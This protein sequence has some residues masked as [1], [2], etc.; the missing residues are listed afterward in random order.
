MSATIDQRVVEMRFDNQQFER[1]AHE[2]ISTLA[3]LKE[4]L[5][6]SG[7]SKGLATINSE[8]K[9][10]NL[11][12]MNTAVET[13]HA[14][15]SALEVMGVTALANI[16]NQ[17][18]NAGKRIMSALTIDPVKTG[19]SEYE[20]QINAVQTI[21]A[22]TQHNGTNIDQV[23]NALETL[24]QYADKTIYNFTEMTRNI[25]TFTAAGV[26]L[27]TSVDS[28]QGI[29]N[30]A[31][32]SGSTSQQ[33]STAMYQ[34]SQALAAGKVSLM[35]WNSVVNAGMGG[36][37]FQDA[38][39]RTSELLKTG[40]KGAIE[41]YGS[42]RESLT[43]GEWLTTEVL[44]ETLKQFAGA[45]SEADLIA[46][47]FTK[48]QAKEIAAMAKTAEDAAT[49][50]KTFSQ[51]W[52]VM[53]ESAQSGWSQT[54]KILIGDFEEAKSLLTPLAD[55]ATKVIGKMSDA[56]NILL[57]KAL[58]N[59]FSELADKIGKVTGATEA[60]KNATKDYGEVV[61]RVL[62]GEFGN[63]QS[64]WDKLS[65]A[66][67]DWAKVQNMV[68]EKLG[69]SVRH[70]EQLTEAQKNQNGAQATTIE[71]L[72]QMSDAQLKSLGFTKEEI[73][74]FRD[75]A[76]QSEKTGI[77]INDLI[78]DM[79]QL[80]G[81]T[82]LING[83]KNA[84]SG[85]VGVFKAMGEAWGTFFKGMQPETLY[86]MIAGFHKFSLKLRLTDSETGELNENGKKLMRTF[87]GIFALVD[88]VA[89]IVGGGLRLAFKLVSSI[90]GY[91][92]M[93]LLD[94]TA[95][96]GD[97]LVKFREMTD[98]SKLFD[99]A[100][101]AIAPLI[102]KAAKGVKEFGEAFMKLPLVQEIISK[103]QESIAKLKDMDLREI[104]KNIIDGLKNGLGDGATQVIESIMEL[105][106]SLLT[107]IKEVL[108][109]HSPSTEFF[110]IGTNII[111]GLINGIVEGAAKIFT[112]IKD[113]GSSVIDTAS[114][115]GIV[116][117]IGK[118][119]SGIVTIIKNFAKTIIDTV[120]GI[121]I[122][123]LLAIG[124]VAGMIAVV[125]KMSDVLEMF[126][127]P[128]EGLGDVFEG[129][130]NMFE[131]LAKNFKA[132]AWE[133]RTKGILNLAI[134]IGV[135]ALSVSL[136]ASIKGTDL[137]KAVV[138]VAA[139][140][141]VMYVL[142]LACDKLSKAS[143]VI[144]QNGAG[145]KNLNTGL[146][147]I[148]G[149]LLILAFTVK[150]IGSLDPEQ[151]KQ[152]F[153][154]L[155]G[156]VGA[157]A[158]VFAAYGLLVKGKG[159]KS[160]DKA[161]KMLLK[162]SVS[163]LIMVGVAKLIAGMTWEDMGKAG[164]GILGLVGIIGL[165]MT[166]SMI[167]GKKI[168]KI[169]SM[170]F[171]ISSAMLILVGVAK[172]IN[173]MTWEEM[174]KAGA[175]MLG[176]VGVIAILMSIAMIPGKNV[177]KV[178]S[179]LLGI[180]ASMFILV[181]VAKLINTMEWGEMGKAAVGLAGLAGVVALLVMI[182]KLAGNDAPK[183]AGTLIAMSVAIGI[184][185]G[186]AIVLGTIKTENL[187]K[188][189]VAVG[190]L[191]G[192]MTAMIW[193]TRGANDCKGNLIIMTVAIGMMAVAVAALSMIDGTK[194]AG[195]TIAMSVLM[196]MFALMTK[197]AGSVKGSI[198]TLITMT[199]AVGLLAGVLYL[200][201]QLPIEQTIGSAAALS[202]L[203]LAVSGSLAILSIIGNN[204]K[205][206]LMGV[207]SL[208]LMAVPL[209]AF[210]GV[211]ALMQNVQ[212]AMNNVKAL[213]L[214]AGA[215]TL[216]LIPLTIIGTFI[217]QA[218]LGVVS[219]TLMAVPLL[220]FVGILAL[221][222]GIE[223]AK[224]N[225]DALIT[226][227]GSLTDMLIKVAIVGPLALM[228]VTAMYGLVGLIGVIGIMATAVGALMEKFPGLESFLDK[229]IPILEKLSF[230]IGSF[231]GNVISG[232]AEGLTDGLPGIA[233]NLSA[234]MDKLAPFIA[235][236]KTID[237]SAMTGITSL[238]KMVGLVSGA[239]II[240]AIASW[241]TGGSSMETFGTQINAFGDAIVAFSKKVTEG[242][243][244]ET[245]VMAAAN[246]GKLM[247]EMNATIPGT[248]GIVQWFTGEKNMAAFGTQLSAFGS[249]ICEFSKTVSA[250]GAINETAVTAA[251]NAGK[252]M[253]EM[254]SNLTGTGGVVQWFCGEKNMAT[255]GIQLV[256]FGKAICDFSKTV[257]GEG[258]ITEESIT[259]AANAGKLMTEMQSSI[260]PTGGVVQFFTG[261]QNLETFGTQLVAFGE[262]IT[263]FSD[264]V[265]GNVN[266]E[267]VTAAANAG[268]IM[269]TLQNDLPE[270]NWFDGK[271]SLEDFGKKLV[272]FGESIADY[273]ESVNAIDNE[274]VAASISAAKKLVSLT[275]SL[276][277]L[278]MSG[279]DDFK[280]NEIGD[281][282]NDYSDKVVDLDTSAINSSVKTANKLINFINS[283]ASLNT[284][285]ISTFKSAIS[286]LST[287]SLDSL[288]TTFAN[289][290]SKLSNIGSNIIESIINGMKLK[291][292]SMVFAATSMINEV[293]NNI[294]DKVNTFKTAGTE[295]MTKM[296]SGIDSQ[297]GKVGKAA[298][299]ALSTAVKDIRGYYSKFNSAGSYLVTGFA[300]GI[301]ANT[302]KAT[303]KARAMAEAAEKAA[304][305][306]LGIHS[307]S[308][309][310][311]EIAEYMVQG[312]ELGLEDKAPVVEQLS[313]DL[314]VSCTNS[315]LSAI[316]NGDEAI[317]QEIDS[318][319]ENLLNA[320][321][322]G[323]NAK[324][325]EDMKL[326]EFEQGILDETTSIWKEYTDALSNKNDSIV[327]QIGL[328]SAVEKKDKVDSDT[329]VK[330]LQDQINE[331][332]SF[333]NTIASLNTRIAD[334]NLKNA[335]NEMGIE[336][337]A[338]LQSLNSMTDAELTNYA[339]MY[340]QKYAL[341]RHAAT[342]QLTSLQTETEQKLSNLFGGTPVDLNTFAQTFD[343]TM[344]SIEAYVA[345]TMNPERFREIGANWVAGMGEGMISS[346]AAYDA[347][348]QVTN[349]TVDNIKEISG[350]HS[351]SKLFNQEIGTYWTAGIAEGMKTSQT[352]V[353][354]VGTQIMF[355]L[356][357][358][359]KGYYSNFL[360]AGS[361]LVNGLAN[362][363]RANMASA[364]AAAEEMANAVANAARSALDIHS[365]S[366]VFYK[367]G[368]F[369]G[370][371]FANALYD[372][373]S[374][375][376]K[377]GEEI[378]YSAEGGMSAALGRISDII[379]NG[380]DAQPT[381]RPILDLSNIESGVGAMN[382][383][384]ANTTPVG[385]LANV[386][387][388]SS[389]M[390][391]RNQNG[392][393]DDIVSA[394]NGL[395]KDLGNVGGTTYNIDGITYD[396]GS[397]I[398]EAVGAIVRAARIERRM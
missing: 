111:E 101:G 197:A 103:V 369:V 281:T 66:G 31:A 68:N 271:T 323:V 246:A 180:S 232:F 274:A 202:I 61:D 256:A 336:S 382:G 283:L 189:I 247:A 363:I 23:N 282:L 166:I 263:S 173:T 220:A 171:K 176:L 344:A 315:M 79:D 326:V 67:Y 381:I 201:A 44:T 237:E 177:D 265:A 205:G 327:N 396:D 108:G 340:E 120:K 75:L 193:A 291:Q 30:L 304:K 325:Y 35:D 204:A 28:I 321:R 267:A 99:K 273:S 358:K 163:M 20:T 243:I 248:G 29:A 185:A 341:A 277:N 330:N 285:G 5:N 113:I 392:G 57:E 109:I 215:L 217:A 287:I 2:S 15:F 17:A 62:K 375:V 200:L 115:L 179:M 360:S 233:E 181:G 136:L 224:A 72:V 34:L 32:V 286:S 89:D 262:A 6:F 121:D 393:N 279:V 118:L 134:A 370:S 312:M 389:M 41:T 7:A 102:V 161:G 82:L 142:S 128:L 21:L 350:I 87:K 238:V 130:A 320:H 14:K 70:T 303:A 264:E 272:K 38:L 192:I 54:W 71:Q 129:I 90:L 107:K 305:E 187:V 299:S 182:T 40:A 250:E 127:S 53:K 254:Q 167:P 236:A 36:K 259:A 318:H 172:L 228:G 394:I 332:A 385:L 186:V 342:T 383:M 3:K 378:G 386:G 104:G 252:I 16:T 222:E 364:V 45:Y 145:I 302:Y 203:L 211:L 367:M 50:V 119:L 301:S 384:L 150:M 338:E 373:G 22:N 196:G 162:L 296:A 298:T 195:V 112:T 260:V 19:F 395:R 219:L 345:T 83:L 100:I 170:M 249:A 362:G 81:R 184:L 365:P 356:I 334:G 94:L 149:S 86:N 354:Q 307:P 138:A 306:A 158:M 12:G 147:A 37:V 154:G 328:F 353:N 159:A 48:E 310:F 207:L 164:A 96:I 230:A 357:N 64:R 366:R 208:T 216:M 106:R 290:A 308:R 117:A 212:N 351:P 390:D 346:T 188:G 143:V 234:F 348:T 51:L 18:V 251:A 244:N 139:L 294:K 78:K 74:A 324:K 221:M 314:A 349:D 311:Y 371:G 376:Y 140:A 123:N 270:D 13:V 397:N 125:K 223:N 88:M 124:L 9:K 1:N 295:L 151:A 368:E 245:A 322:Q 43:Q 175:G 331:Y 380:M 110:E 284:S 190:L 60:M 388:I 280:P 168:D 141:G 122:G 339:N 293:A 157:V 210:V 333:A 55:F 10:V 317:I 261:E 155:A 63:G 379:N 372:Y 268:R 227:M 255:F 77:P 65:E 160:M 152:G 132:A 133:K 144:G 42:F 116:S 80:N 313:K 95:N 218:A 131:G 355:D 241:V 231:I 47:G 337:I 206:A 165:L 316:Q 76:E 92:D 278:D 359:L 229:G 335:I 39:V 309:V 52:D 276:T 319:W 56:R 146:I 174:G 253:S 73:K 242:G 69:S 347:G 292:T 91:F 194:L 198:G 235:G 352:Q 343:G 27:Q 4:K 98:I 240:D 24:N 126:G 361:F 137:L 169:G 269:A 46:Q 329:L 59:P 11:S 289:S 114:N 148:A 25:G 226:L 225:T 209:L 58:G 85:V 213:T 297:K 398:S 266:E 93:D 153:I 178:G 26:D 387:T 84:G 288:E 33:A 391:A 374:K 300:N 156:L 105:G 97:A 258:A 191:G 135:L 183:I 49:K 8:A 377:A 214:L 199:V 257:S 239:T 275:K